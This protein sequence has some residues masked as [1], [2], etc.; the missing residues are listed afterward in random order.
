[1]LT[2]TRRAEAEGLGEKAEI[3]LSDTARAKQGLGKT[4]DEIEAIRASWG[5]QVNRALER[6]RVVE[7]VDHRSY[8]RQG[9]GL[10]ATQHAG[11][12]VSGME[13]KA[14]RQRVQARQAEREGVEA[15]AAAE[16]LALVPERSQEAPGRPQEAPG[17]FQCPWRPSGRC[18]PPRRPRTA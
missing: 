10:E 7:R 6:A 4:A 17:R 3:E 8:A 9:R 11:P 2:T 14:E 5:E 15:S 16:V 13:R 18:R 12:A 1:M